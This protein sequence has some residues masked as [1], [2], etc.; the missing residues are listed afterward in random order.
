MKSY[1]W[2]IR[3]F[4]CCAKRVSLARHTSSTEVYPSDPSTFSTLSPYQQWLNRWDN[5]TINQM[6]SMIACIDTPLRV[7]VI[8]LGDEPKSIQNTLR[9]LDNSYWKVWDLYVPS[10]KSR[11]LNPQLYNL[12]SARFR[13]RL[14]P[15]YHTC[16]SHDVALVVHPGVIVRT[17]ALLTILYQIHLSSDDSFLFYSDEDRYSRK[18]GYHHPFFKPESA[19]L[20]EDLSILL[21]GM[22]AL[23]LGKRRGRLCF[24]KLLQDAHKKLVNISLPENLSPDDMRR[25]SHVL[26]HQNPRVS[27]TRLKIHRPMFAKAGSSSPRIDVV[28]IGNDATNNRIHSTIENLLLQREV[29]IRSLV[30]SSNHIPLVVTSQLKRLNLLDIRATT[31]QAT[32]SSWSSAANTAAYVGNSDILIFVPSGTILDDQYTLNR[33]A[34]QLQMLHVGVV[35]VH[36]DQDLA[37]LISSLQGDSLCSRRSDSDIKRTWR[38]LNT[39]TWK[40]DFV[41]GGIYGFKRVDL[42]ALD[43]LPMAKPQDLY[44]LEL[45]LLFQR[46]SKTNMTCPLMMRPKLMQC[47][48]EHPSIDIL[49]FVQLSLSK[50]SIRSPLF[51]SRAIS[52][53]SH[54]LFPVVPQL[55]SV[56]FMQPLRDPDKIVILSCVLSRGYGVA[57]VV[58][59][60]ARHL[61]RLGYQVVIAG[62]ST[63]DDLHFPGCRRE[64]VQNEYQAALL[65]ENLNPLLTIVHTPPFFNLSKLLSTHHKLLAIDH[66]EP[67]PNLFTNSSSR[68]SV[69]KQKQVALSAAHRVYAISRAVADESTWNVNGIIGLG[70]TH[71]PQWTSTM[72][73]SAHE[74]RAKYGWIDKWVLL[75]VSRIHQRERSYKGVDQ[76]YELRR[77]VN[78]LKTSSDKELV[79]VLCGKGT[80]SD[81]LEL[82][83]Q[84]FTVFRNVDDQ[85]LTDIY[86]AS[87]IYVSYSQ[88]EGYNLG[89]A[90]ALAMGL[91]T[92]ASNIPAHRQFKVNLE[93]DLYISA[94]SILANLRIPARHRSARRLTWRKALRDLT[95]AVEEAIH[96][97]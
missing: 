73:R 68:F 42:M 12:L 66:G 33:M 21:G 10:F 40:L 3:S 43:S 34:R 50:Y 56:W 74:F 27:R 61:R 83:R 19:F 85:L 15:T 17:H 77:W 76:L 26:Y 49:S 23:D 63:L 52:R 70:N 11:D 22:F 41:I 9:S 8:L 89:I 93:D 84:G 82:Q 78:I 39:M 45:C 79:F 46:L 97:D 71:I 58:R 18:R 67:P 1:R 57:L 65:V 4:K 29:S 86:A 25:I 36:H 91:E 31:I 55:Q 37:W 48:T 16:E 64:L 60:H 54:Q 14:M 2:L 96:A 7:I 35:A 44:Q 94:Q 90:Q 51:T 38:E 87:D 5:P 6:Q 72:L 95:A 59:I 75:S 13:D 24:N 47:W 53:Y 32:D 88:W 28:I 20:K 69:L 81:E 92:F 30:V 80:R 62:P